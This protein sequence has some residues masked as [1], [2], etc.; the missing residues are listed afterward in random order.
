MQCLTVKQPWASLLVLGA[1]HYIVRPWRTTHLGPL[2]IHASAK[3]PAGNVELCCDPEIRKLL[4]HG[5]FDYAMELPRQAILGQVHL[6]D[7]FVLSQ[8]TRTML[9]AHDSAVRF[10]L[11]QDG[12]CVWVCAAAQVFPRPIPYLGRLGIYS[13]P[14][15]LLFPTSLAAS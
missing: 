4:R 6:I 7:C 15:S 14:D 8:S 11:A 10:G 13:L 5:G 9:D 12:L 1:T 3:L 2:A